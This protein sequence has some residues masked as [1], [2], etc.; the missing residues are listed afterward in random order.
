MRVLGTQCPA[1]HTFS[2]VHILDSYKSTFLIHTS[3]AIACLPDAGHSRESI[4]WSS[5]CESVELDLEKKKIIL[6]VCTETGDNVSEHCIGVLVQS[7]AFVLVVMH[8]TKVLGVFLFQ[9]Y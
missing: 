9:K 4:F 6:T 8:D 5:V 7:L 1:P 2:L 3:L